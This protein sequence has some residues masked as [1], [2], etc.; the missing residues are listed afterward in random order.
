MLL[1][2]ERETANNDR[3]VL[4]GLAVGT[5]GGLVAAWVMDEF[6]AVW[7]KAS[8]AR[9]QSQGH[10]ANASSSSNHVREQPGGDGEEQEPATVKANPTD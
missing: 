2:N 8:G 1:I 7:F 6:Q 5:I 4:K 9:Q 3:E 10:G